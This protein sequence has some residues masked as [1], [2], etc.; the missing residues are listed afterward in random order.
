MGVLRAPTATRAARLT[1]VFGSSRHAS[2]IC[3]ESA[4]PLRASACTDLVLTWGLGSLTDRLRISDDP[5]L[6]SEPSDNAALFRSP[7]GRS[8]SRIPSSRLEALLSP[9]TPAASTTALASEYPYEPKSI[10]RSQSDPIPAYPLSA[11]PA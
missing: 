4:S 3:G 5:G 11:S 10:S 6:A 8:P 1:Q 9:V 7:G 2:S